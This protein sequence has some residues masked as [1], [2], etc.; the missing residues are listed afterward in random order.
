LES[1]PIV[2]GTVDHFLTGVIACSTR[3]P[4]AILNLI[5]FS[6]P[7]FLAATILAAAMAESSG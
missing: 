5:F 6:E 7:D 4:G 1:A 3:R 2:D